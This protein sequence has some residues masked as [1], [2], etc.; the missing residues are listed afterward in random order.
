MSTS[1]HCSFFT[2]LKKIDQDFD[3]SEFISLS[4]KNKL[5]EENLVRITWLYRFTEVASQSERRTK[6]VPRSQ[7]RAY[8]PMSAR[9]M[10]KQR[11]NWPV[12]EIRYVHDT[13]TTT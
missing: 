8:M 4:K 3:G 2:G 6:W 5:F 10:E 11:L 9:K 7:A 12:F 13:I 1:K